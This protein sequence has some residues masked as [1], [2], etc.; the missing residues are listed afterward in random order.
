MM[1]SIACNQED[2]AQSTPSLDTAGLSC[3]TE[4][5]GF[6][7]CIAPHTSTTSTIPTAAGPHKGLELS[8]AATRPRSLGLADRWAAGG[9]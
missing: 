7:P 3:R 4:T 6:M 5:K 9:A 2:H 8:A 1:R